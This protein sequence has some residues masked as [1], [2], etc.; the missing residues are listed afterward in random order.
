MGYFAAI[1]SL[2][3]SQTSAR[4]GRKQNQANR[5]EA[6]KNRDFQERMSGTQVQRRMADLKMSGLNPILAGKFDAS[7]PAG[8]MATM[9]NVGAAAVEG[10]EKGGNTARETMMARLAR[11]KTTS[12]VGLQ[13]RLAGKALQETNESEARTN[14][15]KE[16]MPSAQAEGDL[17]RQL[18]EQGGTAKGIMQFAPLLKMIFGGKK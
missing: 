10:A 4:G 15:L 5:K 6:Q 7:S 12:D 17:W 1:A 3:G 13:A 2:V 16:Q 8:N 11:D 14:L 18:N 9:G